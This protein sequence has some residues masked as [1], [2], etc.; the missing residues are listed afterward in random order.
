MIAQ[1]SI[2]PRLLRGGIF[3][4]SGLAA[5]LCLAH[6]VDPGVSLTA[7]GSPA[8]LG[9]IALFGLAGALATISGLLNPGA[10]PIWF[11]VAALA[12][13]VA[14]EEA[15]LATHGGAQQAL[16]TTQAV[17]AGGG[18]LAA[19]GW[20]LNRSWRHLPRPLQDTLVSAA[21]VLAIS[22]V[23]LVGSS[24]AEGWLR[25][26]LLVGAEC[27]EIMVAL[28]AVWAVI[29][30]AQ[31]PVNLPVVGL[32]LSFWDRTYRVRGLL[33]AFADRR[34]QIRLLAGK[35]IAAA[36]REPT[37]SQRPITVSLKD[38]G[39][40]TIR[41]RGTD[42]SLLAAN[43]VEGH[44]LPPPDIGSASVSQICELGSNV[45]MGLMTLA[46]RYPGARL[47]GVE[48]HSGNAALARRNVRNLADRCT[49]VEA[50]IWT[51]DGVEVPLDEGEPGLHRLAAGG[52][53]SRPMARSITVDTL[54]AEFLPDG[55]I[56]YL[57]CDIVGLE[58]KILTP[59]ASW[60]A[61]V[62]SIK[63]QLYQDRGF[64]PA[65]ALEVL[66]GFGM[67]AE[68]SSTSYGEFACGYRP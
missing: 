5:S 9:S 24:L 2:L 53:P 42:A 54:L 49:L 36:R 26:G 68:L 13:L 33:A 34:S 48:A 18:I 64:A 17:L 60:M 19:T 61:R 55:Q 66:Q 12:V 62:R 6:A 1:P 32:P 10:R 65:E 43:L 8:V 35:A 40:I 30:T 63:I 27:A 37:E 47:L 21:A 25:D 28:L 45:G 50:A 7:N 14:V 29:Q 56:D 58:P 44:C 52:D 59:G 3:L 15:V 39:Q 22:Q 38:L 20:S 31:G 46:A 11:T 4:I 23:A 16:P 41:P 51:E 57:H 67:E